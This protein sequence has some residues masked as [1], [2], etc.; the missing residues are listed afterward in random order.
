M[1]LK[2]GYT[3][4]ATL[5]GPDLCRKVWE[6]SNVV[7]QHSG[8]VRKLCACKLHPVSG[9]TDK[10]NHHVISRFCWFVFFCCAHGLAYHGAKLW[11]PHQD[12]PDIDQLFPIMAHFCQLS[13][14][15]L[16]YHANS[17]Q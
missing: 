13:N 11:N 12:N 1:Y 4:Q 8:S 17:L 5:W 9:I 16:R 10:S 3:V 14:E 2:S 7:S 15:I 6:R